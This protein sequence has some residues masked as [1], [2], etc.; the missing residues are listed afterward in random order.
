MDHDQ[1]SDDYIKEVLDA[2]KTVAIVG[3]SANK[4]RPS[5]FVLTYMKSKGYEVYPV[6]PGQAGKTIAGALCYGTMKEIPQPIHMV[7]VFR[8]SEAAYDVVCEALELNPLPTVIWMQLGVR[9]DKAAQLAE[10]KGVKVVM[11][12]CPKIEYAR[13][14]GEIGWVGVNSGVVSSK[15]PALQSGYQR[16][17]V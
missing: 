10:E 15:K 6:N 3:A 11:N 5:Y 4:V 9:N 17:K 1:Y 13:L 8:N 12:R 7:D 2:V 14:C 16:Y